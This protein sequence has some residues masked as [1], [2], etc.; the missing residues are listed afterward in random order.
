M[1]TYPTSATAVHVC[2]H[3]QDSNGQ[4]TIASL[5]TLGNPI[6]VDI[7]GQ[8]TLAQNFATQATLALLNS[9][10]TVCDT[11]SV[12]L[13]SSIGKT[14]ILR[15]GTLVTTTTTANQVILTF[16]V[17]AG[18]TFFWSFF[19]ADVRNTAISSTALVQGT[20]SIRVAGVI[21]LTQINTNPTT[22]ATDSYIL[23]VAEPIPF[24]AGTVIDVVCTPAT[25]TSLTWVANIGGYTK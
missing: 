13:G 15:T 20:F 6:I 11:G 2:L 4:A 7:P 24:A 9:K 25:T 14:G 21:G 5:G 23:T 18:K 8:A 17:P 10:I 22:S 3:N 16:T 1:D 12:S 19:T